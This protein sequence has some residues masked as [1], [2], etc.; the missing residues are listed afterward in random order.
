MALSE[1]TTLNA[2]ASSEAE[3]LDFDKRQLRFWEQDDSYTD[4]RNPTAVASAAPKIE[5]LQQRLQ[6]PRS[7]SVLDVGAG[8]GVFTWQLL[9]HFD[10]VVSMDSAWHMIERNPSHGPRFCGSAYDLPFPDASFDLVFCGNLLHHVG[11]PVRVA[12]EMARVSRKHVV[13]CE[14]N[15]L[16][17]PLLAFMALIPAERGG[18]KFS[19]AYVRGLARAAGLDVLACESMGL[20]Y[21]RATPAAWLPLLKVFDGP[22][23]YGAYTVMIGQKRATS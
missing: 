4:P 22:H 18:V 11:N 3:I 16:N 20:I 2:S 1:G 9:E 15:R 21:E 17:L 19:P 13:F 5:Y 10:D 7:T 8:N 6:L 14:P 12:R 23:W